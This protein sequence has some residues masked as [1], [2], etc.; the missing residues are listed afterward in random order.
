MIN[1]NVKCRL[2]T[3]RRKK[4]QGDNNNNNNKKNNSKSKEVWHRS[5][6]FQKPWQHLCS[7]KA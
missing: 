4:L 1:S 3:R 5:D 6:L 2:L 7:V